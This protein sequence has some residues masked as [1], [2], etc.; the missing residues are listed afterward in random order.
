MSFHRCGLT[1]LFI[2]LGIVI[3]LVLSQRL[4]KLFDRLP[5]PGIVPKEV[6]LEEYEGNLKLVLSGWYE[7]YIHSWPSSRSHSFQ[8]CLADITI[9]VWVVGSLDFMVIIDAI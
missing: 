3:A 9:L 2:P 7:I 6:I 8:C 4:T 5:L 1:F